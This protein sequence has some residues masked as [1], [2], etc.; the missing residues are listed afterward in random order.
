MNGRPPITLEEVRRQILIAMFADDELMNTLVL[1]GGNALALVHEVGD[2]AS[3]DMDFSIANQFTDLADARTRIFA[4][5]RRQFRDAGYAVFDERFIPKPNSPGADQPEWWGGYIV[6][7]KLIVLDLYERN[8]SDLDS[9]RRQAAILGPAQKRVYT[10]DISKNEYCASKVRRE[11]DNYTVYVYSLE[12]IAIEKLRAICQQMPAYAVRGH[13]TP[14]ARDFYDIHQIA[15]QQSVDLGTPDNRELFRQIF[16]AKSVPLNL[17]EDIGNVRSFHEPDW[18][19]VTASI[20]GKHEGF[21]Y[22]FDYVVNLVSELQPWR[23][24]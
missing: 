19:A 11:V 24:K 23:I 12:M 8:K 18:P 10:I 15:K 6:E 16:S 4:S 17:L 14:R 13:K 9:L 22:Y 7:F 21:G 5:L 1:K 3:L 20:S 2:R